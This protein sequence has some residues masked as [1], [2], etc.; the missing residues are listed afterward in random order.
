MGDVYVCVLPVLP[1]ALTMPLEHYPFE[2]LDVLWHRRPSEE[3]L[4]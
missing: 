4:Q 3:H 2:G 1:N